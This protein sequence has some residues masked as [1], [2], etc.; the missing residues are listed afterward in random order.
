V[1][2]VAPFT[3]PPSGHAE[4]AFNSRWQW[5]FGSAVFGAYFHVAQDNWLYAGS[6]WVGWAN[7]GSS[8]QKPLRIFDFDNQVCRIFGFRFG[9]TGSAGTLIS[10]C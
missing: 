1:T 4:R 7:A 3:L 6:L 9:I 8:G 5:S 10:T 2:I